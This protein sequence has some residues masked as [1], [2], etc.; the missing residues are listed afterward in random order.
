M[1]TLL[2]LVLSLLPLF[3]FAQA[4]AAEA[5]AETASPLVVIGFIALFV[6]ACIAYVIYAVLINKK[7]A[8]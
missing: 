1:K 6:G 2:S 5:P 3:A 7:K 4:K 8:D